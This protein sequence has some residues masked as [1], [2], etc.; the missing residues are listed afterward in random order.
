MFRNINVESEMEDRFKRAPP[1]AER[2][3]VGWRSVPNGRRKFPK[4]AFGSRG[5]GP[6][7]A[8]VGGGTAGHFKH[9]PKIFLE[10]M[11]FYK[12]KPLYPLLN[13]YAGE[14]NLIQYLF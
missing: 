1:V 7:R 9:V 13:D 5:V 11:T 10:K 8:Q 2:T 3:R 14:F 6:E 12:K 4:R